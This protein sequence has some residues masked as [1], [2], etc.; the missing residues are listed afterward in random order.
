[1]NVKFLPEALEDV[2]RL[3]EFLLVKNPLAAQKAMLAID[4]GVVMLTDDPK[5][6]RPIE[7]RPTYRELFVPF[8]RDAYILR[9]RIEERTNSLIVF[10]VWHSK[11]KR[12]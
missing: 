11:E 9:Y 10:R 5:L 7:F 4:E 12:N 2:E 3:Y 1:M 6:G 8:G